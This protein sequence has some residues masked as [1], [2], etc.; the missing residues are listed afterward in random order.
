MLRRI[1]GF[2]ERD[3]YV[4]ASI[5]NIMINSDDYIEE[6]NSLIRG[7]KVAVVGAG[8]NLEEV[9]EIEEDVIISADGATN[10][11]VSKGITPDIVVTDLDGI[12]VFPDSLY[13]VLAH[14]DNIKLLYKAKRMK[15]LI[16]TCQVMPF[17]RLRLFGGFTDGDR[18]VVLAKLFNAKSVTLYGMD[19][20]SGIVGKYSKP[21][22]KNNIYSS[23]VK[24]KKLKIA[25]WIIEKFLS[26][27]F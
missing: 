14:G 20:D 10:Y 15:R 8:P 25:K 4:S 1:F 26:K 2:S 27:D 19:F 16:G 24:Q 5:L 12:T 9:T 3:D 22:Y 21:Y 7:R 18:A 11:L 17:G 6:L 13:V 23:W